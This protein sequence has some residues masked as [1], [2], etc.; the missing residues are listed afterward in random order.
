M[1]E[2]AIDLG[3][4]VAEVN[5]YG[6]FLQ[7]AL[8]CMAFPTRIRNNIAKKL[9]HYSLED[10]RDTY[11][12]SLIIPI[13]DN[14]PIMNCA[15][16]WANGWLGICDGLDDEVTAYIRGECDLSNMMRVTLSS[17]DKVQLLSELSDSMDMRV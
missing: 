7:F 6:T 12:V 4:S 11:N 16:L 1:K 2:F 17:T 5:N 9:L 8:D 3:H 14:H 10:D 15:Y 13:H